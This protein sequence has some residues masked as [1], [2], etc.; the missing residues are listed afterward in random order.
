MG[1]LLQLEEFLRSEMKQ[2]GKVVI[3]KSTG[4]FIARHVEASPFRRNDA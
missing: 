4:M 1:R 3:R 2:H